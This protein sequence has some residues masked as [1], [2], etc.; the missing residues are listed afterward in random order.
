MSWKVECRTKRCESID[1]YTLKT[2]LLIDRS[3]IFIRR[4]CSKQNYFQYEKWNIEFT[5]KKLSH[6]NINYWKQIDSQP[7]YMKVIHSLK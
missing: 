5:E 2:M 7:S 1:H 4:F 6:R 3:L